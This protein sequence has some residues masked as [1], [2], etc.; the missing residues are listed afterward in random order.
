MYSVQI[1]NAAIFKTLQAVRGFACS[2]HTV[3][4][5]S[6]S[7]ELGGEKKTKG[8]ALTF[9]R[10][11]SHIHLAIITKLVTLLVNILPLRCYYFY[12]HRHTT[13]MICVYMPY[14]HR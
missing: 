8:A 1:Q 13:N 5:P 6:C 9:V 10:H 7:F 14:P 12:L 2:L 11:F 4:N 3:P